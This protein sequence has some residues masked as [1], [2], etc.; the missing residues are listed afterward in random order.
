MAPAVPLYHYLESANQQ[1][2]TEV[3]FHYSMHNYSS[4]NARFEHSNFFKVNAP[5]ARPQSTKMT[6][7]WCGMELSAGSGRREADRER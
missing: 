3:L 5:T 1:T 7:A 2:R 4:G 6:G